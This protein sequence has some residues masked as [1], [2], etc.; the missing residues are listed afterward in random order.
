MVEDFSTRGIVSKQMLQCLWKD[1]K[2]SGEEE[3][4]LICLLQKFD[5]CF[6]M[7]QCEDADP[8]TIQSVP[9]VYRFPWLLTAIATCMPR[10]IQ[11]D[12]V[13]LMVVFQL[14]NYCPVGLFETLSVKLNKFIKYRKDW[15][16]G[17]QAVSVV[18]KNK[19][20]LLVQL[21]P[22]ERSEEI[23]ISV[24]T[25]NKKLKEAWGIMVLI[26][27]ATKE[28]L[29]QW[30]GVLY[31]VRVVCPHCLKLGVDKPHRFS[32]AVLDKT[33]GGI[34]VCPKTWDEIDPRLIHPHTT[35]AQWQQRRKRA[36][37]ECGKSPAPEEIMMEKQPRYSAKTW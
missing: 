14:Q 23:L 36:L 1:M 33:P 35:P 2:L 13:V 26:I 17:I 27:N 10:E 7:P 32:G 18:G 8:Y 12:D 28:L 22:K 30:P 4:M 31:C 3:V 24:Q 34:V 9:P 6:E 20:E 29:Q 16:Y 15:Q 25:Q 11:P 19:F 37:E 5:L 21:E